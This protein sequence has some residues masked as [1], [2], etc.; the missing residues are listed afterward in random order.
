MKEQAEDQRTLNKKLSITVRCAYCGTDSEVSTYR[1]FVNCPHCGQTTPFPGFEYK[2]IDWNSS[3]YSGVKLWMDCPSCR[4]RN[5]YLG[6]SRRMWKCPDCGYAI[7]RFKKLTS[8]FWFCD[9]CES[10]LNVQEGFTAKHKTWK[11]SECGYTNSV[12]RKDIC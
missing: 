2:N 11:C 1:S 4:S 10:F 5:M 8:V 12:T 6:P 3:M 7:S 9:S